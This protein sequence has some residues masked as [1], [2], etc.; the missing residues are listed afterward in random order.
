MVQKHINKN[1]QA[2]SVFNNAMK[3]LHQYCIYNERLL[4]RKNQ[5]TF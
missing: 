1:F 2:Q 3:Q 5:N 4:R